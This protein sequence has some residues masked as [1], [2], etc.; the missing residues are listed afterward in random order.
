MTHEKLT[1]SGRFSKLLGADLN[2]SCDH[3]PQA[4]KAELI[5]F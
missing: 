3:P 2:L 4:A 5:V 1:V